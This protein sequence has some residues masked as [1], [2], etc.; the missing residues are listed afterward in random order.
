[1]PY[2]RPVPV[3]VVLFRIVPRQFFSAL[4]GCPFG[5]GSQLKLG[6]T[7][8]L[9]AAIWRRLH[10]S[11]DAIEN[12]RC[13]ARLQLGAGVAPFAKG[14][15]VFSAFAALYGMPSA[16]VAIFMTFEGWRERLLP[17]ST[18]MVRPALPPLFAV[19]RIYHSQV[20]STDQ[21]A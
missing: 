15:L 10:C 17:G 6:L 20:F 14:S 21:G 3:E 4:P 18:F 13:S 16:V 12:G 2:R 19:S 11:F 9:A 1:V 8:A 7:S 5:A